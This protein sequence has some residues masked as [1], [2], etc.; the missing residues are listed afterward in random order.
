MQWQSSSVQ[1]SQSEKWTKILNSRFLQC[2]IRFRPTKQVHYILQKILH[3]PVVPGCAGCA[4][5]HPNFGRS[6]NPISTRGDR[7]CSPNYYW[8]TWTYR[9]SDGPVTYLLDCQWRCKGKDNITQVPPPPDW[10][11]CGR[12]ICFPLYQ[13]IWVS[14]VVITLD[15]QTFCLSCIPPP[16]ICP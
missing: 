15:L 6:V 11:E 12:K 5:A 13:T 3:R 16:W 8:H 14:G 4:M 10:G 9:P 7:L 1:L 2:S